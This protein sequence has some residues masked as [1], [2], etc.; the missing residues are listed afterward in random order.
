[1][2]SIKSSVDLLGIEPQIVLSVSVA[3]AIYAEHDALPCTITSVTEGDHSRTSLHYTG[4][5][6]DLRTRHLEDRKIKAI[7]QD[8]ATALGPG[9]DVV[10]EG[11]HIHVEWQPKG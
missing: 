5:A 6:V 3:Y 4:N 8:L 11:D 7:T 2:L 1:M 9:Y 10:R